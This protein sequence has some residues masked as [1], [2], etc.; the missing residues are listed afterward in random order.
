MKTF[1]VLC[2][3]PYLKSS[4]TKVDFGGKPTTYYHNKMHTSGAELIHQFDL[5]AQLFQQ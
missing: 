3:L 1:N 4:L 2:L 5:Q